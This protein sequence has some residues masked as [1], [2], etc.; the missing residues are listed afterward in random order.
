MGMTPGPSL[1]PKG[2]KQSVLVEIKVDSNNQ[3]FY[4][5]G[6][7]FSAFPEEQEILL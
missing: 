1:T 5:N 6:E 7:N 2:S 4:L 3:L